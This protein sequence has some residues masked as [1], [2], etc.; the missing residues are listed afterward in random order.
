MSTTGGVMRRR[1]PDRRG[2]ARF[3]ATQSQPTTIATMSELGSAAGLEAWSIGTRWMLLIVPARYTAGPPH[4]FRRHVRRPRRAMAGTASIP[5]ASARLIIRSVRA[6]AVAALATAL[7]LASHASAASA[8]TSSPRALLA[9]LVHKG[10]PGVVALVRNGD[11]VNTFAA[12]LADLK[13]RRSMQPALRFRVGSLSKPVV[14]TLVLELVAQQ[15][16]RLS[17]TVGRWLPGLIPAGARITVKELLQHRSGLFNYTNELIPSLITGQQPLNYVWTPHQ[18]VDIATA[19][20]LDFTPGTR[21]EYSNTNYIVLGLIVERVTH[22]GLER[23]AHQ[24]LFGPLRMT[25]TSFALGRVLGAHAH[26]YTPLVPPFPA[27]PGGLGDTEPINGSGAWAAGSLVTT[28]AD[29]D[30]FYRAL[31][32]GRVIPH[33]LVALMQAARPSPS[34]PEI[35]GYG[36]GLAQVS[37][38][39]GTTWGHEGTIFGYTAVVAASRDAR[40]I[41]VLLINRDLLQPALAAASNATLPALYCGH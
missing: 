30:R 29:L 37:Y 32:T 8:R 41:V 14:A 21:F 28:A 34:I 16:L 20:P 12:G 40:K 15:R 18:L 6:F 38:P 13:L 7:L 39:C 27:V 11:Q 3:K 26:G 31:F 19:H 24:T 35:D 33:S 17:D 5:D 25:S 22:I 23:Y 10:A 4:R 9:A 2:R 1:S 36:L